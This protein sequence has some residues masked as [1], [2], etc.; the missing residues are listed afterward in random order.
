MAKD[1]TILT[2]EEL[3]IKQ[4]ERLRKN[5]KKKKR[6]ELWNVHTVEQN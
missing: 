2:E 5:R 3:Y 4:R 1:C 6:R